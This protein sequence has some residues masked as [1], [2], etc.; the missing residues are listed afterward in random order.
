MFYSMRKLACAFLLTV[1]CGYAALAQKYYVTVD[2]KSYADKKG[3]MTVSSAEM[4][5]K[6]KMTV[7]P[8]IGKVTKFAMSYL[9]AR[10]DYSGPWKNEQGDFSK[11]EKS[12]VQRSRSGDKFFFEDIEVQLYN[13]G[14]RLHADAI[15]VQIQ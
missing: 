15:I 14:E 3:V 5:E 7:V 11:E 6:G 8:D 4:A 9:P 1:L 13:T 12:V 2:G 10:G